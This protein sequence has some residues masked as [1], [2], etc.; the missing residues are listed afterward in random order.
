MSAT[1]AHLEGNKVHQ[2]KLDRI[3][4][5]PYKEEGARIREAAAKA[6]QSVQRYVLDAVR[7][8]MESEKER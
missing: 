7:Q 2:E 4:M 8:R 5:Q 6:G 3:I 1:K